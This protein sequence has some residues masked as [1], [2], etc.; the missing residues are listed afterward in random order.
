MALALPAAAQM[1]QKPWPVRAVIVATFEVGADTGDVPGEFQFWVE[2]EHL[3]EVVDFPGGVHP[4]RTNKDHTILGMVSGTTLVNA[5]A[6]M[7]ALGL[8]SRFD[9]THAYFLINGIA[10]VDPQVASLGSAAWANYVVGDVVREID[11]REA[12]KDWPYGLFPT[13]SWV[14]NPPALKPTTWFASNLYPLNPKLTAWAFAQTK[15]LK[16][17]DDAKAAEFRAAYTSFPNAQK[18]PFVLIGT[19]FASDYFWHG[20]IMTQFARDWVRLQTGGKGRFA[21]TEMEDSGFMNAIMRLDAMHR[22]DAGRVMVLRTGS[23]F[24]QQH[25]GETALESIETPYSGMRIALE[26]AYLCGSTVLHSILAHWDV[27][28]AKIPGE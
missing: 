2:R 27:T 9:L 3:D 26:S 14:P 8:D 10:G 22:V 24:T 18:P 28:Y 11:P 12:P 17:A 21:M 5:T 15:D 19:S 25:A 16:L 1:P 20:E 7:M 13:G 6:S 4:L 23:N